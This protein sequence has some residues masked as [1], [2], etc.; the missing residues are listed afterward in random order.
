MKTIVGLAIAGLVALGNM[1]NAFAAACTNVHI[2]FVN[3][4]PSD[5]LFTDFD[6]YD[7]VADKFREED[8]VADTVIAFSDQHDIYRNLEYVDGRSIY[9]RGQ[10][11]KA[12]GGGW[13]QTVSNGYS[14]TVDCEDDSEYF[15]Y[16]D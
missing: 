13:S 15:V 8:F 4:T 5:V 7:N 2:V 11:Q 9:I 10:F 3:T 6:Y 14:E 1:P 12:S 16:L